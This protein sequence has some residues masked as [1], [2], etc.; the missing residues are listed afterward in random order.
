MSRKA[1]DNSTLARWRALDASM[2]VL[3]IADHAKQD[4]T[5]VP[6]KSLGT[7]RWHVTA[8]GTDFELLCTGPRFL[9]TR[10]NRGGGGAV[11][12]AMH[13]HGVSFTE[14]VKALKERLL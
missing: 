8:N 9:D 10:S 12:L 4:V 5:F 1:V 2:V 3:C 14:A 7:T 11:D 6:R 13:L